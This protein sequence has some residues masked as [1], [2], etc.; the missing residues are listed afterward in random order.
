MTMSGKQSPDI[1]F[2]FPGRNST[3]PWVP[4][5]TTASALNASL[6]HS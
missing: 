2:S 1:A 5:C 6:I 3:V 4:M